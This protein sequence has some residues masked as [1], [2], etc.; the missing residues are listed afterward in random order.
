[1]KVQTFWGILYHDMQK[2]LGRR[3]ELEGR[4]TEGTRSRKKNAETQEGWIRASQ[5]HF[6]PSS[7]FLR[8]GEEKKKRDLRQ[9]KTMGN[10]K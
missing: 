2:Q 8:E 7:I 10:R 5:A 1:M 9:R 6:L 4:R 3:M